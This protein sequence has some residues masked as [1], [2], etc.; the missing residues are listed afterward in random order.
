MADGVALICAV[1]REAAPRIARWA[2]VGPRR[3][4]P[5][6]GHAHRHR[7]GPRRLAGAPPGPAGSNR[8]RARVAPVDVILLDAFAPDRLL[9]RRARRRGGRADPARRGL[10]HHG[11]QSRRGDQPARAAGQAGRQARRVQGRAHDRQ[12]RPRGNDDRDA[13]GRRA[14]EGA[15]PCPVARGLLSPGDRRPRPHDRHRDRALLAAARFEGI[16]VM[17]LPDAAGR[18]Y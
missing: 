16:D 3:R 4:A 13:I 1:R 12:A 14:P 11:G 2:G 8:R 5:A 9:G 7:R 10:R 6:L 17:P 18:T 15:A